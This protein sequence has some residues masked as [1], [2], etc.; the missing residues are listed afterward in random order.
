MAE[1]K[2]KV[3]R[4]AG[5]HPLLPHLLISGCSYRQRSQQGQYYRVIAIAA[6]LK[7]QPKCGF[8][9]Q[10]RGLEELYQKYKDQGFEIIGFPCV[11][12]PSPNPSQ[13]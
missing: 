9:P 13:G 5:S 10:Y 7:E 1:Y 12:T 3:R 2:G 8:T 6:K 11:R 4:I